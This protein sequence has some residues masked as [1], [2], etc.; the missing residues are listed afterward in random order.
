MYGSE[1]DIYLNLDSDEI[2]TI[3]NSVGSR[4]GCSLGSFLFCLALQPVIN[5]LQAEFPD[6]LILAYCDDVMIC[7]E[8]SRAIKALERYGQL[9]HTVI[10]MELRP[11][12]T[13]I[14]SPTIPIST[15]RRDHGLPATIPD[16]KIKR[17]GVR[18]LGCPVGSDAFKVNFTRTTVEDLESDMATLERCPSLHVQYLLVSKSVQHSVTHI[19]RSISGGTDAY[20][21][22]AASYDAALLRCARRWSGRTTTFPP[23]SQQ[24]VFSPLRHGGLGFRSWA[25]TADAAYASA[26]AHAASLLPAYY[27]ELHQD[28]PPLADLI[29]QSAVT[30]SPIAAAALQAYHR[31]AAVAPSITATLTAA[32]RSVRHLQHRLCEKTQDCHRIDLFESV[33]ARDMAY[34]PTHPRFLA[35]YLSNAADPHWLNSV[36]TGVEVPN[37]L[38]TIATCRRLLLPLFNVPEQETRRQLQQASHLPPPPP[39]HAVLTYR[40]PCCL[41]SSKCAASVDGPSYPIVDPY[42]DHALNCASGNAQRTQHWHDPVRDDFVMFGKMVGLPTRSEPAGMFPWSDERP[43]CVYTTNSGVEIVT[44]VRT[45]CP[46]AMCASKPTSCAN[47][48]HQSGFA[49]AEGVLLKEIKWRQNCNYMGYR[50]V[51]IAIENGGLLSDTTLG[52][53]DELT[54]RL[55]ANDRLRFNTF[56]RMKLSATIALGT[57]RLIKERL[58]IRIG[59]DGRVLPTGAAAVP[60]LGPPPRGPSLTRRRPN[61]RIEL[62]PEPEPEPDPEPQ[63]EPTSLPTNSSQPESRPHGGATG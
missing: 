24:L 55:P 46:V 2:A 31:L 50:F 53:L 54:N 34:D 18:V 26:Y 59:S 37:G 61:P 19:L 5:Q 4:Q 13:T 62:V 7:G 3:P 33:R 58:P 60:L 8:A 51:A 43:D 15:L 52:L 41:R 11:D 42:G 29:Q 39:A 21:A 28:L 48:S 27:P 57:A 17:D 35:T 25:H 20:A 16:A 40:C 23:A 9:L 10:Q 47:A 14:Y 12:K 22:V 36:L 1:A 38:F 30:T 56:A 49:A 32:P 45:C 63:P 6:L 44:D